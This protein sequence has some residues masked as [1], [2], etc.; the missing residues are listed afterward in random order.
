LEKDV[1][2]SATISKKNKELE[3]YIHV[4]ILTESRF[5]PMCDALDD[6]VCLLGV[7]ETDLGVNLGVLAKLENF[8]VIDLSI[9]YSSWTK[10][11]DNSL[12][13]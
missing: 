4:S 12:N 1:I 9:S 3:S 10:P 8:V 11:T 13:F 5:E 7:A 6:G 2:P